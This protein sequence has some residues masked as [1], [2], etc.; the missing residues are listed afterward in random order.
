MADGLLKVV[1]LKLKCGLRRDVGYHV[2]AVSLLE[3]ATDLRRPTGASRLVGI[4]SRA[5]KDLGDKQATSI[6]HFGLTANGRDLQFA[7]A[8][9][10]HSNCG[11]SDRY[12]AQRVH[13]DGIA[14]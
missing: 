5:G 7:G 4:E 11:L 14:V 13:L 1:T 3:P 8:G 2:M 6:V 12:D 10:K 9:S